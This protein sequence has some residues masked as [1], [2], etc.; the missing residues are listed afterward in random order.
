[1]TTLYS[2][3]TKS[4]LL[5]LFLFILIILPVQGIIYQNVKNVLITASEN[6]MIFEGEKIVNGVRLDPVTVPLS[7]N[8]DIRLLYEDD[9]RQEMIFS[10]PGFPLI[11]NEVVKGHSILDSLEVLTLTRPLENSRGQLVLMMSRSSAGLNNRLTDLRN[12]LF[13]VSSLSVVLAG[14]LVYFASGA[15]L[16]PLHSIAE[17]AGKIQASELI[18]RIPVPQTRDESRIL[19]DALNAMLDRIERTMKNQTN[20]FASATHELKTPLAIMKAELSSEDFKSDPK[21]EGMALEVERL[22]RVIS[23]FLL[24]SQ[25]KSDSLS[26]RQN[27]AS[28]DEMLYNVVRKLNG[29][30]EKRQAKIRFHLHHHEQ[31]YLCSLDA[32][33]METVFLNLIEN[34]IKYSTPAELTINLSATEQTVSISISNPLESPI[35]DVKSL[36][37]EFRKSKELSDGLG[38]GLW[39]CNEILRLHGGTIDLT[40]DALDFT[41][42]VSLRRSSQPMLKS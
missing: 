8:Y 30:K 12:Y 24:I 34:A 23:D 39:I 16:K 14:V 31:Q 5:F 36:L 7:A 10:S 20:F 13:L 22:D 11:S 15:M 37:G 38:M 17:A 41:V 33:K 35:N 27:V 29:L 42:L 26:I 21:W 40:T 25:L 1:M 4:S 32:D 28:V 9:L 18:D 6:E 19:A 3:R 2:I